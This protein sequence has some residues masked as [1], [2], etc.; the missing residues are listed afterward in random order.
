M[1]LDCDLEDITHKQGKRNEAME[2]KISTALK[3]K[4]MARYCKTL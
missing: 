2:D 4:E 3:T 1:V